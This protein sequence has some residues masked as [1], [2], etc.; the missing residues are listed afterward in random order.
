MVGIHA[1]RMRRI[2]FPWKQDNKII[3]VGLTALVFALRTIPPAVDYAV[4]DKKFAIHFSLLLPL[5]Y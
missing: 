4:I 5:E 2:P 1:R 3:P